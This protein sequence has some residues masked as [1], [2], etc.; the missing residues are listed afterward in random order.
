M[1]HIIDTFNKHSIMHTID[2]TITH[3]APGEMD[4]TLPYR[5]DLGQQQGF[6]HA[7]II[8]TIVDSACGLAALS[9]MPEN[10]DVVTVE[11]KVNFMSPAVGDRFVGKGR[12]VR[13]G[14]TLTVTQGDVYSIQDSSGAEK[15]IATMQATMFR[16]TAAK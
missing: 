6:M 1:Q 10:S 4:I 3:L 2:A 15:H 5:A 16:I 14:K 11:F 7:G 12:V 8:T 9:L 13:S